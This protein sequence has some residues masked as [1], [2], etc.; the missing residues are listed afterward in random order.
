MKKLLVVGPFMILSFGSG[1]DT[2]DG[3]ARRTA[4]LVAPWITRQLLTEERK[5][6]AGG[7]GE[8]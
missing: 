1:C 7:Y 6:Q 8:G 2:Q 3:A 5:G 4:S